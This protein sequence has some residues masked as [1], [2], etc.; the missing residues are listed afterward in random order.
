MTQSNKMRAIARLQS[1]SVKTWLSL[2]LLIV[3]CALA[4]GLA[5]VRGYDT[6]GQ[7]HRIADV[8]VPAARSSAKAMDLF[9]QQTRLYENAVVFGEEDLL[10]SA[11]TTARQ[12]LAALAEIRD[13][14]GIS[15]ARRAEIR[16]LMADLSA[17]G[18]RAGG[19]YS[20][21]TASGEADR[22]AGAQTKEDADVAQAS[23]LYAESRALRGR[24]GQLAGTYRTDVKASL[25]ELNEHENSTLYTVAVI[26]LGTIACVSI[27]FV[28]LS[29]RFVRRVGAALA[30]V[31]KVQDGEFTARIDR[32][33][34]PDEIGL[35][36]RGIN[37]MAS[38]ME[39]HTGSLKALN[40]T[41]EKRVTDRTLEL[42]SA[43]DSLL[44]S[45]GELAEAI[46]RTKKLA[47]DAD[48]A[49]QAKSEFLAN[50]SHEIRTPMNGV[51]GMTGLLL[52]TELD[53][54]QRS[55]AETVRTCGEA[56]L[57]LINDILDFSKIE[58][59][60]LEMEMLDFDLRAVVE[61][62]ADIVVA[63]ADQK[64]LELSC[65]VDP[66]VPFLL[67]GDAGRLR[68]VLINLANNAVKFTAQG[69]VAIAAMLKA[70]TDS[71]ATVLLT[72]RDTGIGIAPD[73]IDQMFN[74]FSQADASTTRK[75]GGTGLGLAISK[76]IAELMGGQI[77]VES[78]EG[79]GSTFWFTAVLEKQ[80]LDRR[81]PVARADVENVRVLVVDDNETSRDIVRKYLESWRCRVSVVDSAEQ[82]IATLRAA[83]D[84]GD[85][86][87]IGL[88]DGR[89]AARD[90]EPLAAAIE[91]DGRLGDLALVLLISISRR[92]DAEAMRRLVFSAFLTR[93][94]K[95]SQLFDCVRTVSAR[96]AAVAAGA[97]GRIAM[98]HSTAEDHR[99]HVRIL[100]VEDNIAN[101]KV[102]LCILDKKLHC[103]AD[104]VADGLEALEA[105]GRVDYDLVLM[106]C[107][108]PVMD[109]YDATRAIRSPA[110]LVRNHDVPVVAMT[111]N[112][113]KGDR[114]KCLA[115][116]MNDY[117][118]KPVSAQRLADVIVRNLAGEHQAESPQPQVAAHAI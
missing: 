30:C 41:L 98:R 37:L 45:N 78:R 27:L 94:V 35:L 71:H 16:R 38:R 97:A 66:E 9:D 7:V 81:A 87:R 39:W 69:E 29:R 96:G 109:G 88:L 55:C 24:L 59:G 23:A 10:A 63:K 105:L 67:R 116:G 11:A 44:R 86:F 12:V 32:C 31:R 114:Q 19:L 95:Q 1:I 70:E 4:I 111:A 115:A 73:R 100:V 80:P 110:S 83:A 17:Y 26:S 101:Q 118:A 65:Y 74:S 107:Q 76:Q 64:D 79:K 84:E 8:T 90:D 60:K 43:N 22:G 104:A 48:V 21:L 72:V 99:P 15:P 56:L 89:I 61:E 106:D 92:G 40:E 36:Q 82:A 2:A 33:D 53:D 85:P 49:N 3:G 50:M 52:D 5:F 57:T 51:I 62:T 68:Q 18:D 112:A 42:A 6:K 91:A 28:V 14:D 47:A 54:E 117:I 102:A 113:M 58:A 13:L 46:E 103:H 75:Y 20:K 93:P 77:D 108:M 25:A 34:P